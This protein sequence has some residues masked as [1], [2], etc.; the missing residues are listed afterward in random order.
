M[1]PY[2]QFMFWVMEVLRSF[3]YWWML[4]FNQTTVRGWKAEFLC[5]EMIPI[6]KSYGAISLAAT[7]IAILNNKT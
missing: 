1:N 6:N 4:Y 7:I 3:L 2:N 5:A